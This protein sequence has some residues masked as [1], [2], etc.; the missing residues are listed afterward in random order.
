MPSPQRFLSNLGNAIRDAYAVASDVLPVENQVLPIAQARSGTAQV[1]ISGTYTGAEAA[2]Y[3]VQIVDTNADNAMVSAPVFTGAGSGRIPQASIAVSGAAQSYTIELRKAGTPAEYASVEIEGVRVRAAVAGVAG[4]LLRIIVDQSPLVFTETQFSTLQAINAGQGAPTSA[5]IGQGFDWDDVALNPADGTIPDTAHRVALGDDHGAVYLSYKRFVNGAYQYY[6]VPAAA[7][8]IP[9]GAAVSFVTGGRDVIVTNGTTTETYSG[10]VTVYD[11]LNTLRTQSQLLVVVG[12]APHDRTPT[13]IAARELPLRTDAHAEASTGT[14]SPYATGFA[15]VAVAANAPTELITATCFDVSSNRA[16]LGNELWEL[17]GTKSGPL[18]TIKTGVPYSQPVNFAGQPGHFALTIPRKLPP[19]YNPQAGRF[20]VGP[21]TYVAREGD[22]DPPPICP[23]ALALGPNAVNETLTLTYTKR[24]SGD[25]N[26]ADMPVPGLSAACL[27]ITTEGNEF[28]DYRSD[29]VDRLRDLYAWY[30]DTVRTA[31]AYTRFYAGGGAEE[32]SFLTQPSTGGSS[33]N[34]FAPESLREM[35]RRFE[36][37]IAL[38]DALASSSGDATGTPRFDGMSAW[39]IAVAEMKADVAGALPTPETLSAK[40]VVDMTAGMAVE[41]GDETTYPGGVPTVTKVASPFHSTSARVAFIIANCMAGDIITVYTVGHIP[42]QSGLTPGSLYH[43]TID[44]TGAWELN[45]TT[46]SG[47]VLA[48]AFSATDLF[49]YTAA[50]TAWLFS[51][52]SDRYASRLDWA[53]ISAGISPLGK[54]EASTVVSGD[55]C[56]RDFGDEFYWAVVGSERGAYAPAFNN[57]IC[58]SSRLSEN[59]RAY[60]TTKEFGF[61]LNIKCPELLLPGDKVE[62]IISQTANTA[63]YQNGDVLAVGLVAAGPAYLRGGS[64]G[65]AVAEWTVGGSVDGPLPVYE[66]DADAPAPYA[67][68]S[69]LEFLIV[70]GFVPFAIGDRFRFAAEGGH[71]RWRKDAGAWQGG[72]PGL[73]L[74]ATPQALDAGLFVAFQTGAADSFVV[75]DT[76]RFNATQPWALSNLKTPTLA[77]WRW[78]GATA[79]V[80][81]DFGEV[82][83]LDTLA[84]LHTLPAGATI[85]VS[86]GDDTAVTW[87][88]TL[89]YRPGV[90]WKAI[91]RT[92]RYMRVSVAAATGGRIHWA[93]A[94]AAL[95][96]LRTAEVNVRR[97][98]AMERP[99]AGALQSALFIGKSASADVEW[100]EGA[101]TEADAAALSDMLDY[102]KENDDEALI[103]IPQATRANDAPLF[104]KV[105]SDDVDFP[106]VHGYQP[107]AANPRELS[108]RIPLVGVW[109]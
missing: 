98:Y 105:N 81:F 45:G 46:W 104:A 70:R 64:D 71:W 33:S 96:T 26:C 79:T 34:G 25:C 72:S 6:L 93:W 20:T 55:G 48:I 36:A 69:T 53:L 47:G 1:T 80:D 76:F 21:I 35:V 97:T 89:T 63:T 88:E 29:T 58:Y 60:Y 92:A 40:A 17:A 24:P 61:I 32:F 66:F 18:G 8:D 78:D 2:A 94:G 56:W 99:A 42:G 51:W 49:I 67:G 62:L 31:S 43:P 38:I 5:L 12:V 108:A 87:S 91:D 15:D 10:I 109:R 7:R 85:E 30:A 37:G 44:A 68:A 95:A 4:D 22:V 101:L 84:L 19:G 14:G 27:G 41:V 74:S 77:A 106:D 28:M 57:R 59:G 23:A 3:D 54:A 90:I 73:P 39:D 100:T 83:T 50:L 9:K 86:G 82:R 13:G 107:N 52:P 11:L 102:L 16:S 65:D 75:G 103:F